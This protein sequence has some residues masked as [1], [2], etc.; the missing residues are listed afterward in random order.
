MVE[1]PR[2][3]PYG[4]GESL[5]GPN[6]RVLWPKGLSKWLPTLGRGE[7]AETG[8][9]QSLARRD[10][11]VAVSRARRLLG[12]RR[13]AR[14]ARGTTRYESSLRALSQQ[15]GTLWR[16]TRGRNMRAADLTRSTGGNKTC[17]TVSDFT[18]FGLVS[19]RAERNRQL[20]Q[21]RAGSL[22]LPRWRC[23]LQACNVAWQY[24]PRGCG[25]EEQ[26]DRR[27]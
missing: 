5:R 10:G 6:G 7:S 21:Q 12:K 14:A 13:S 19:E 27:G 11:M 16:Q 1:T 25:I 4:C 24:R 18:W 20:T 26:V 23:G 3:P 9:G 8:S 2:A 15:A 22:S 17:K